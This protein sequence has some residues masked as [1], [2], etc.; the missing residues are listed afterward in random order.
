MWQIRLFSQSFANIQI[1]YKLL[2]DVSPPPWA[3]TEVYAVN[4]GDL[5]LIIK[6]P[7]DM[8]RAQTPI[9][10]DSTRTQSKTLRIVLVI[11]LDR[12]KTCLTFNFGSRHLWRP[13]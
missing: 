5:L 6:K 4:T 12:L 11:S 9:F 2:R 13:L 10:H 3:K 7:C 8:G 1:I